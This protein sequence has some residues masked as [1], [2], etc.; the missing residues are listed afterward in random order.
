MALA[1]PAIIR[2]QERKKLT[3]AFGTS[4]PNA[5]YMEIVLGNALGFYD[6]ENIEVEALPLGQIQLAM[7]AV[8]KGDV[9]FA[10]GVLSFELPLFA[11]GELPPITNFMEFVYP[12]KYDVVT[13]PG[14]PIASYEDL[15]GKTLG[16]PSLATSGYPATRA[17]LTNIG[18]DPDNDVSWVAVGDGAAAAAAALQQGAIDA[19]AAWDT[20]IGTIEGL[21]IELVTLPRPLK[22]PLFG[23][24]FAIARQDYIVENR[25]TMVGF[26][27]GVRKTQEFMRANPEAAIHAFLGIYPELAPRGMSSEEAIATLLPVTLRRL[28]TFLPPVPD[29]KP[30]AILPAEFIESAEFLD[31]QV[32]NTESLF[33]NELVDEMNDFDIAA[34][35]AQAADYK[36]T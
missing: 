28:P 17:V 11:R 19:L 3:F 16:V 9:D 14:S 6:E 35:E 23:G 1:M 12:F 21:G 33:T 36:I 29:V 10:V 4:S 2:A 31:L 24:S 8:D 22:V 20:V 32:S 30:G 18:I 7:L 25:Q 34:I 13:L 27:R 15:K 26:A 5:S